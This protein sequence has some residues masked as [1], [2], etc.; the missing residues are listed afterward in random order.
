MVLIRY[1]FDKNL[2]AKELDSLIESIGWNARGSKLWNELLTYFSEGIVY[3]R[4][5]ERLIGIVRGFPVGSKA[6]L[7][8]DLVIDRNYQGRNLGEKLLDRLIKKY[9]D[10]EFFLEALPESVL[11]YER[12][13]FEQVGNNNFGKVPMKL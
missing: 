1:F 13:G 4:E 8:G 9:R 6:F 3:V 7:I 12:Y 2:K 5:K 10:R 11:F